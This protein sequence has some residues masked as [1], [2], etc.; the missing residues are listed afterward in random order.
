MATETVK[1][2]KAAPKA[3]KTTETGAAKTVKAAAPKAKVSKKAAPKA[4]AVALPRVPSHQE[5]ARLA[6]QY[7]AERGWQDGFAE[8]D[9]LRAER[10]LMGIAS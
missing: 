2:T 4:K 6:E 8:Q 5:I 3:K 10:E 7:W 9:W 1:K